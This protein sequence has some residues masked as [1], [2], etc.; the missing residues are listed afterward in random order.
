M[1]S[2]RRNAFQQPKSPF[3]VFGAVVHHSVGEEQR[4]YRIDEYDVKGILS[5][6][7]LLSGRYMPEMIV[8]FPVIGRQ[9]TEAVF[10]FA[11]STGLQHH[12]KQGIVLH[13]N[14]CKLGQL[15]RGE[16]IGTDTQVLKQAFVQWGELV[17]VP[18]K[19]I[20]ASKQFVMGAIDIGLFQHTGLSE[21]Q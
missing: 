1:V 10:Q 13:P 3:V 19:L 14:G 5:Q 6:R 2:L 20:F 17:F 7:F 21:Q 12:R 9:Y 11:G 18:Q 15:K 4:H 8:G 16:V